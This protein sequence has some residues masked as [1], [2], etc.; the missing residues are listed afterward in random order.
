MTR[1]DAALLALRTAQGLLAAALAFAAWVF[2]AGETAA[3]AETGLAPA[4][5]GDATVPPVVTDASPLLRADPFAH[6]RGVA[7]GAA[8]TM[9]TPTTTGLDEVQL[10]G[11]VVSTTGRS[12]AVC[13]TADGSVR[14]V[15]VN[16]AIGSWVLV[17]VS[18]GRAEFRN[19]E[20]TVVTLKVTP[21]RGTQ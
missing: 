15:R 1:D 11:T 16:E 3:P 12:F 8:V 4:I 9:P 2:L 20:G 17:R 6:D 19:E 10:L 7:P 18:A 13:R 14:S 21:D 5:A